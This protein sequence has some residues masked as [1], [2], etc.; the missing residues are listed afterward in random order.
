MAV[1]R[2]KRRA[3]RKPDFRADGRNGASANEREFRGAVR[4]GKR[5]KRIVKRLGPGDIA[6][7]DHAEIDRVSGEDLVATGVRCVIN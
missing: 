7:I 4:L 1:P 6:I 5:T 2:T 3:A